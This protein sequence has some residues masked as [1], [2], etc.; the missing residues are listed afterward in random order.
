MARKKKDKLDNS[1]INIWVFN[2]LCK[3]EQIKIP[4]ILRMEF[5]KQFGVDKI[6]YKPLVESWLNIK[7]ND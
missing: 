5:I 1:I 4:T 3:I 7:N 6:S 2:D